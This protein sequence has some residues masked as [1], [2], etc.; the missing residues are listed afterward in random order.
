VLVAQ[1][2]QRHKGDFLGMSTFDKVEILKNVGSSWIA[3]GVTVLTGVFLSPYILHRLGDEAFGI[4]VLIFSITGY[5]GLF[6]LGIRSSIVRYVAKYSATGDHE[7]LNRLINTAIC[8]YAIIGILALLV[9]ISGAIYLP[10]I[11]RISSSFLRTAR[12]LFLL[13]GTALSLGFPLGVF[14]GILQG[15]QRFDLA[16]LTSTVSTL[17]RCLLIV[18]TL[19]HGGRLLSVALVTVALPVVAAL[20]NATYALHLLPLQFS[21]RYVDR[22]S[23]RRIANY[24]SATFVIMLSWRLRFKTDAMIIGTFLSSAAITYF[25]V[26]SRL[27]DYAGEVVAGL[28][29]IF[30]PMA[31][32]SVATGDIE[33]V[34]KILVAGNRACA[35]IIF[36]IAAALA[37]LGKSV[38]EVWV[39]RR[40]VA[41]SYPVL[42]VIL[43][44][45]TFMLAQAASGR[46]L[47]GMAKHHT[48]AAV[49][50]VEGIANVG[51]SI[52]LVRRF[53]VLGDALGTA[54]PL[55]CTTLLFLPGHLCRVLK[56]R[57]RTYLAQAFLLPIALSMPLV[58]VLVLMRHWFVVHNLFQLAIQLAIVSA[59]YSLELAW[60]I[61]TRKALKVEGIHDPAP[62]TVVELAET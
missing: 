39:G 12:L 48:L 17:L 22:V 14:G 37:I 7:D 32:E 42:L 61:R 35:L 56:L 46:V 20:V 31:S 60:I 25:T 41:S 34:R 6:D 38:I 62:E 21:F 36:P 16:N 11:F 44:P 53:G 13:V 45:S 2:I 54:I 26:G 49:T 19:Q 59:V 58:V 55:A 15:L 57:M 43:I 9:T 40:Y 4:W 33:H 10:L 18:M 8:T 52:F 27:V 29:Q 23:L 5:Y 50:L 28:A 47:F 51:L 1:Q 30:D 24:S 3:L